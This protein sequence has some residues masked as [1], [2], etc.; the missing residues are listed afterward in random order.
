[1]IARSSIKTAAQQAI[2]VP[3]A[4]ATARLT[5]GAWFVRR[6]S[7]LRVVLSGCAILSSCALLSGC[8]KGKPK[9]IEPDTTP[10]LTSLVIQG[11]SNNAVS[12]GQAVTLSVDG[13]YGTAGTTGGQQQALKNGDTPM[14]HVREGE[15]SAVLTPTGTTARLT[16][17]S[18]AKAGDRVVVEVVVNRTAVT[19]PATGTSAGTAAN[20]AVGNSSQT[21]GSIANGASAAVGAT[22][23]PAGGVIRQEYAVT[24]VAKKP[25]VLQLTLNKQGMV[26][27]K[28]GESCSLTATATVE[29]EQPDNTKQQTLVPVTEQALWSSDNNGVVEVNSGGKTGECRAVGNGKAT[30][31][32]QYEGL[33]KQLVIRVGPDETSPGAITANLVPPGASV[34]LPEDPFAGLDCDVAFSDI[35]QSLYR[36]EIKGLCAKG[37]TKGVGNRQFMP[38]RTVTKV[39]VASFLLCAFDNCKSLPKPAQPPAPDVDV[40]H[41]AS[42]VVAKVTELGWM[43]PFEDPTAAPSAIPAGT[44]PQNFQPDAEPTREEIAAWLARASNASGGSIEG[45]A[46]MFSDDA[47]KINPSYAPLVAAVAD[48]GAFN[49]TAARAEAGRERMFAPAE[50]IGR[51]EM[52]AI[53]YHRLRF[54]ANQPPIAG[55]PQ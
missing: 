14:W 28:K 30:V 21:A 23:A 48:K 9:V 55:K 40:S 42:A 38:D 45:L 1:M 19:T 43:K 8:A 50:P 13:I 7:F 54:E 5:Q 17:N 35:D 25:R 18:E 36:T 52:A 44:F 29:S 26:T 49:Y 32:V 33:S 53:I 20:N 34:L 4:L 16:I 2:E 15:A 24:V 6:E 47:Q 22:Q 41:P 12:P 27:L 39:E 11:P 46:G 3:P 51:G 31:R 37:I 10:R